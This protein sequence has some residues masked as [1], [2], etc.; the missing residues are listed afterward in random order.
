[1]DKSKKRSRPCQLGGVAAGSVQ[2]HRLGCLGEAAGLA[3]ELGEL[4]Q[5]PACGPAGGGG[6]QAW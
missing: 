1:M 5:F 4:G 3:H 2:R 6:R